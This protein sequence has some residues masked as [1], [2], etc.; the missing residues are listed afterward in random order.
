MCTHTWNL[1][2]TEF[3]H[4]TPTKKIPNLSSVDGFTVGNFPKF[5]HNNEIN[6]RIAVRLISK[7]TGSLN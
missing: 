4:N 1:I 2:F 6:P 7:N 3:S 5:V